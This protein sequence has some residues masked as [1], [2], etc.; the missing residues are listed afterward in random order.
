M[1]GFVP[2]LLVGGVSAIAAVVLVV[3]GLKRLNLASA[4]VW[5]TPERAALLTGV[6]LGV[7]AV[8]V[9]LPVEGIAG[10]VEVITPNIFGGL[11]AGLA[12]DLVGD[13][14]FAYLQRIADA[15]FNR[16]E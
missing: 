10:Y 13:S 8:A 1:E 11:A 5:L 12:Y 3:E 15:A 2:E 7:L 16:A 9:S 14:F 6:L 4:D